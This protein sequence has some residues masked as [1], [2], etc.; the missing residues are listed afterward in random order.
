MQS[1][2]QTHI[3]LWNSIMGTTS[4]S[5]IEILQRFQC[6]TLR[7]IV[8]APWDIHNHRIQDDLEMNTVLGEIKSG[9]PNSY[10]IR[11]PH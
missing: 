7:A 4:S 10:K 11:K 3:D 1:T 8:N 5:N 6:K 9:I 2:I